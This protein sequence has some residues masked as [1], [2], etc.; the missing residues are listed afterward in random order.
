MVRLSSNAL[1]WLVAQRWESFLFAHWRADPAAIARLLPRGVEPDVRDGSAWVAIV[2]FVMVGT[3]APAAPRWTALPPIPELNVRTYVR[4]RGVPAVW[5]LTLDASSPLF[6]SVGRNLYGLRYHLAHMA[7]ATDGDR[8]HYLSR[9]GDAAF[10]ATYEPAGPV[11]WAAEGSLEQFL[12]E[13]YRLFG[14]RRGRL[15]TAVVTHD[16][17]PLQPATARIELNRMAPAGLAF[18]GEPLLHFVRGVEA[19]ISIPAPVGS[20]PAATD[21]AAHAFARS[22][23]RANAELSPSS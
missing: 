1:P 9:R 14:E 11:E 6:V 8:F 23:D 21:A 18:S 16:P 13:R 12:F 22:G 10:S 7:T 4:V 20:F 17:W 19:L 15:V 3:R 5:F 2:A